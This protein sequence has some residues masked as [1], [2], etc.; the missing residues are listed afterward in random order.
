MTIYISIPITGKCELSQRR[1][2]KM[3]QRY[4]E[5]LG[6]KVVNPFDVGE[7]L[8]EICL[9]TQDREPTYNEYLEEDLCNVEICSHIFL[10]E[11]WTES[12]G[13]MQEVVKSIKH[14]LKILFERNFKLE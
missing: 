9:L 14:E 1:K 12:F 2:A 13:C 7:I 5:S 10:C 6:H 11:G 3:F 4:F 8:K